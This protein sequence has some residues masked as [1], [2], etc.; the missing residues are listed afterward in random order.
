MKLNEIFPEIK[1]WQNIYKTI[2]SILFQPNEALTISFF[3]KEIN[4]HKQLE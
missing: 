1:F 3:L 2:F 4:Q